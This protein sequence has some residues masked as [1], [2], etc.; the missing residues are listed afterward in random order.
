M[1]PTPPVESVHEKQLLQ[2][3]GFGHFGDALQ[4]GLS[5]ER[6]RIGKSVKFQE[7]SHHIISLLFGTHIYPLISY[8]IP[9]CV[10]LKVIKPEGGAQF[11]FSS[12]W[13]HLG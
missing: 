4:D 13:S 3:L 11:C 7:A 9:G 1:T 2:S 10:W 5:G 6:P 12:R 8:S